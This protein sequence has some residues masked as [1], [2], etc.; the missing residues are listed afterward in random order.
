MAR[1]R[2]TMPQ[3]RKYAS[4]ADRQAAYRHRCEQERLRALAG[5]G[6]PPVPAIAAMPGWR[7]WRSALGLAA[8]LVAMVRQEMEQYLADRSEAWQAS[9]R[10]DQFQERIDGLEQAHAAVLEW[11]EYSG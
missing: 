5:K 2:W 7:R 9:E 8:A 4:H 6:L 11:L 10:G 1:F 3:V